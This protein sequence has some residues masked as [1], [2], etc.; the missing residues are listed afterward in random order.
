MDALSQK[1]I[2]SLLQGAA[3]AEPVAAPPEVT[4]YNFLRPPRISKERRATLEAIHT[5]FALSAQALL[6]SRLREPADV[7]LSSVEQATFAE[8]LLSLG[9]P[10]TAFIFRL[11]DRSGTDAVIDLGTGLSY[12][13]IDRLF[14]GPGD[15]GD[16]GRPLTALEQTVVWGV[17]E[18]LLQLYR[19]AWGELL[20][21]QPGV[22]GYEATPDTLQITNREDN[23]VVGNFEI[24]TGGLTGFMTLCLPLVA[25]EGFL[26]EK[27]RALMQAGRPPAPERAQERSLIEGSVRGA[28]VPVAVRFPP[29]RLRGRDAARLR[30]GQVMHTG[31]ALDTPV[32][33]HLNGIR[34]FLGTLGQ[35]AGF[36]S[37]AVTHLLPSGQEHGPRASTGRI[38]E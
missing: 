36:V 22:I 4:P 12:H 34:R 13:M 24:R 5:R 19:D 17:V 28:Q 3:P 37:A 33:I 14:G 11:G 31:R 9:T 23:V 32:E 18:R 6:S 16:V 30:V 7:T 21:M 10:C 1:D 38:M 26:Q 27:G 8:F 2:D 20:P 25:L 35:S 29:L 15:A